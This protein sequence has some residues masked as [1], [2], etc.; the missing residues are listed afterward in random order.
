MEEEEKIYKLDIKRRQ[1]KR[2]RKGKNGTGKEMETKMNKSTLFKKSNT[3]YCTRTQT[4][5]QSCEEYYCR[6]IG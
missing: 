2:K 4:I 5:V 1:N 6:R 3:N